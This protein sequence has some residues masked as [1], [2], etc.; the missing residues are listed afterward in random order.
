VDVI[1]L[2]DAVVQIALGD[3]HSC[4]LMATGGV[5]CW[6]VNTAGQLGDGEACGEVCPTPVDVVGLG[7]DVAEIFAGGAS[8]CALLVEDEL[9]CWGAN[10]HGDLGDGQACGLVCSMPVTVLGL[11][12]AVSSMGMGVAHSC[13]VD[14][15]GVTRCWGSNES[16]E[17]GNGMTSVTGP[18]FQ[19]TPVKVIGLDDAEAVTSGGTHTC[20]LTRAGGV[21]CWGTNFQMQIGDGGYCSLGQGLFMCPLPVDAVDAEPKDI[22]GDADCSHDVSS[23]DATLMLQ[24]AA[25]LTPALPC[26]GLGDVA[27]PRGLDPRDALLVLQY[28]AGLID[29]LDR[30]V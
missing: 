18:D 19:A 7:G 23:L 14:P 10:H 27:Q 2:D 30:V 12:G 13:A 22:A 6:G 20:A 3:G 24:L 4:A 29:Q 16:G 8:T 5:K 9:Q 21:E 28:A 15:H 17:L 26:P 11:D 25:A 1:G